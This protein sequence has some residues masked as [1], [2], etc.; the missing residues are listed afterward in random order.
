MIGLRF[1]PLKSADVCG[2][3]T[4]DETPKNVCVGGYHGPGP[5]RSPCTRS[6]GVVHGPEVDVS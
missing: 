6:T 3:G 4:R 2:A 5:Q 1:F